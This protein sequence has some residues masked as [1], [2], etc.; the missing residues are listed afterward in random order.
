MPKLENK[1]TRLSDE[2]EA[3]TGKQSFS[4]FIRDKRKE[5]QYQVGTG[6]R[7]EFFPLKTLADNLGISKAV[8]E[9]KIYQKPG[10]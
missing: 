1:P 7:R 3:D 5:L 9:G 6:K 8:L 4:E 10:K 2:R